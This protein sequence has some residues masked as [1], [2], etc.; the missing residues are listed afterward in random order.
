[1]RKTSVLFVCRAN[2]CRSPMAEGIL[3]EKIKKLN[4]GKLI[5]VD[6][7][8]MQASS[9]RSRPDLRAQKVALRNG[10]D[11][12]KLR[13]RKFKEKDLKH[14]YILMM[15]REQLTDL[16]RRYQG[17]GE[18][19]VHLFMHFCDES[20]VWSHDKVTDKQVPDPYYGNVSGFE[21]VYR[22]LDMA[23]DAFLKEVSMR[24][25]EQKL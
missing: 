22:L 25:N 19:N 20:E 6:S 15:D 17:A 4:L 10:V 13:S 1:M 21:E 23:S 16:K 7:A 3:K 14:D 24:L 5:K 2:I 9:F 12:S 8:G 11:I 18:E